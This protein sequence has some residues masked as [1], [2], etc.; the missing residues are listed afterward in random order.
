MAMEMAKLF[1]TK[2]LLTIKPY[3]G[4]K[5]KFDDWKWQF[6]VAMR[7][8]LPAVHAHL[9]EVEENVAEDY[10]LSRMTEQQK[11]VRATL[12]SPRLAP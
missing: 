7:A 1:D 8:I 5:T 12:H 2:T 3:E 6:M 10:A 4:E 11:H 9:K